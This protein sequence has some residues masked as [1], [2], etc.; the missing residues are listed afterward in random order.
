M[1]KP[2]MFCDNPHCVCHVEIVAGFKYRMVKDANGEHR[3]VTNS[4]QSGKNICTICT[5]TVDWYERN[6]NKNRMPGE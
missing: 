1:D 2:E 4:R 6:I 3:T 5:K